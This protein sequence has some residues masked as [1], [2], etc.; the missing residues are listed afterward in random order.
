MA[1]TEYNSEHDHQSELQTFS[2][3]PTTY[4]SLETV[5]PFFMYDGSERFYTIN[6]DMELL[7]QSKLLCSHVYFVHNFISLLQQ[8]RHC[9]HCDH[10]VF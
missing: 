2:V 10:D 5:D 7:S 9:R 1:N 6:N 3:T 8:L 4:H